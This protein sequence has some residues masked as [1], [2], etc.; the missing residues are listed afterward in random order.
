MLQ[1]KHFDER[2]SVA[3]R[4]SPFFVIK[5]GPPL[6]QL[7][8]W[9]RRQ[10]CGLVAPGVLATQLDRL[11]AKPPF[12]LRYMVASCLYGGFDLDVILPEVP[13]AGADRIDIWASHAK[14]VTQREM[15]EDI[16]HEA[17]LAK[18]QKYG[19]KLACLTHYEA[20]PFGLQEDMPVARKLGGPGT[21]LACG[22]KWAG[23]PI[24]NPTPAQIKQ[25]VRAFVD[26]LKPHVA[27]AEETGTVIAIE[28]HGTSLIETPDSLRW[29]VEF[30]TSANLGIA[31]APY[32]LPQDSEMMARLIED[33]GNRIKLF[34]AWQH[35]MGAARKLPKEQELLQMPG[36]GSLDFTPIVGA[37]KK[38]NFQGWTEIFMH[39]VPRGIPILDTAEGVT[40]EINRARRYLESCL[41][42]A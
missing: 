29:L 33:L 24:K 11:E 25:G 15:V 39:P 18:L 34:Y 32:H 23:Q 6:M 40:A 1:T 22:S 38:I 7:P 17:F 30:E 12:R 3:V 36:R 28:N 42:R 31:L 37:L 21:L 19:L 13:K 2:K 5:K 8:Q 20:G 10:F 16:G 27:M 26:K 41:A 14:P 35:G 9:D 4:L